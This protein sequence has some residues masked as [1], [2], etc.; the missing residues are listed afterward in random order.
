MDIFKNDPTVMEEPKVIVFDYEVGNINEK[1]K[2]YL[3][4]LTEDFLH[5]HDIYLANGYNIFNFTAKM[6]YFVAQQFLETI[7]AYVESH[8]LQI[9]GGFHEVKEGEDVQTP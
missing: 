5:S 1:Q 9:A 4:W 8:Y 2:Y 7:T 6:D 3:Y